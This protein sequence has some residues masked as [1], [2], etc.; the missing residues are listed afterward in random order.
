MLIAITEH[1][2]LQVGKRGTQIE[3]VLS[4]TLAAPSNVSGTKSVLNNC[5][6]GGWMK[7]EGR[8]EGEGRKRRGKGKRGG[9]EEGGREGGSG[10]SGEGGRAGKR[11]AEGGREREEWRKER[12]GR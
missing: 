6:Q 5:L 7:K 4:I 11:R 1:P 12:G 10:T 8:E 2:K 9:G 3:L